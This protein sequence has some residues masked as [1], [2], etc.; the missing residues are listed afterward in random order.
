MGG[1]GG[2]AAGE[3][4]GRIGERKRGRRMEKAGEKS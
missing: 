1:P 4:G 2:E 3:N